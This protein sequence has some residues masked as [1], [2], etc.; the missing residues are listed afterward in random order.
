MSSLVHDLQNDIRRSDK[1]V[2]PLPFVPPIPDDIRA[3]LNPLV[4]QFSIESVWLIGSRANG[5]SRPDSDWDFLGFATKDVLRAL[6]ADNSFRQSGLHL[7]IVTDGNRFECPWPRSGA[8]DDFEC[9]RLESSFDPTSTCMAG[10]GSPVPKHARLT[11]AAKSMR[12]GANCRHIAS[13]PNEP[14]RLTTREAM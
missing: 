1:N 11:P 12:N 9:G 3:Y 7:F 8:G 13:I 4:R 2:K 10:V 5:T 6:R 14:Q